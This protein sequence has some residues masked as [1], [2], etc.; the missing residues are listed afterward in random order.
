MTFPLPLSGPAARGTTELP[1]EPGASTA[2]SAAAASSAAIP[3]RAPVETAPPADDLVPRLVRG[4]R[5]AVDEA[6][7]TYHSAVRGLARRLLGVAVNHS[8]RH[9]RS[10]MRRRRAMERL[11]DRDSVS[12]SSVDGHAEV[13]RRQLADRLT[14][15]LDQL[16]FDQREAFVLCEVEQRT[17]VEVSEILGIPEGTVRTRVFHARKKLREVLEGVAP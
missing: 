8:R 3:L 17:S 5:N 6:Y 15:A 4:D 11:A 1:V 9:V 2:G 12:P 10:V 14:L 13:A 7:R 16:S